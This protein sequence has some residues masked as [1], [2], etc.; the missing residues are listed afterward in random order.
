MSEEWEHHWEV[1]TAYL[2]PLDAL[3]DNS[4]YHRTIM[5]SFKSNAC[6][7][8]GDGDDKIAHLGINMWG[9][10]GLIAVWLGVLIP[11]LILVR[12]LPYDHRVNAT[13]LDWFEVFYRTGSIIYGGGQV[14]GR[15]EAA[16]RV[17]GGGRWVNGGGRWVNGGGQTGEWRRQ[18]G[19]GVCG[20]HQ[21][22]RRPDGGVEEAG[23]MNGWR[24]PG[25]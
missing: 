8:Q 23:W 21:L 15:M 18:V 7:M 3:Y 19:E 2:S 12:T 4:Q 25:G 9:G 11:V 10:V 13:P 22:W 5:D 1:G 16:R 14:R 17:N 24:R 20:I 6:Y